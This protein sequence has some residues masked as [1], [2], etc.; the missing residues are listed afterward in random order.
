MK[1]INKFQNKNVLVLGLAKSGTESAKLLHKLEANVT[2]N[3][4][5]PY[6]ENIQAQE[7]EKIGVT[8][9]CGSHPDLLVDDTLDYLIKN[10]GIRYDHPLVKKAIEKNIPVL[11]EV[12]LA[13]LISEAEMI[14][15]TG[16]NG[17]TTTTTYIGQMLEGG[18]KAPLLAGNIGEVACGVAQQA[19]VENEMVMELSSFQ[20]MGVETFSPKVAVLL[21]FVEAHLDYHGSMDAYIE[22]KKN[23]FK[24]QS[25]D[26]YLIYNADDPIVAEVVKSGQAQ[27]IPF[28]TEQMMPDG[29]CI[30]D[31]WLTVFNKQLIPA[32]EMSLPGE[33]N[34]ANGLAAA[35]AALLAGGK[36]DQIRHVLRTF[37]GVQHRLQYIG[38]LNNRKF[39]NNSK[40]T[41]VPATITALKA[42]KD[43][44]VLIAGGL[45]RGLSFDGLIPLLS[46]HVTSMITYGE[47]KDKLSDVAKRAGV[48]EV[49]MVDSLEDA[50]KKAYAHSKPNDVILLSPACASW[51]QF[52]TFEERGNMFT[53][54][55]HNMKSGK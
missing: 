40:A 12:E 3:D 50:T 23:I 29:A 20:L 8:V 18:D 24:N 5:K 2:V 14:G 7:V 38:E 34:I 28:S 31:G 22:A 19:T 6:E 47:T 42:F 39:Y 17:K 32:K 1:M 44:V 27:K 10:P 43:P 46:E 30:I 51:D 9:I 52:K 4:Q 41:N 26:D 45:D 54:T 53:T 35:A 16:S 25:N 48:S 55:F 15:I 13:F 33:H 49:M 11:T 37:A 21:N 36:I